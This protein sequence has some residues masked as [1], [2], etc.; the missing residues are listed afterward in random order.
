MN[1]AVSGWLGRMTAA[2]TSKPR[3]PEDVSTSIATLDSPV[4]QRFARLMLSGKARRG[5]YE[6]LSYP[7]KSGV[8]HEEAV[9]ALYKRIAFRQH[10]DHRAI[11]LRSVLFRLGNGGGVSDGFAPFAPLNELMLLRAGEDYGRIANGLEGAARSI[12]M[13]AEIL[14]VVIRALIVPV[15]V[16]LAMIGTLYVMGSW[17]VPDLEENMPA[18]QWQGL[19]ALL[20]YLGEFTANSGFLYV[21]IFLLAIGSVVVWSLPRWSGRGRVTA[22]RFFPYSL[23]RTFVG[24]AWLTVLSSMI[25]AG[26]P[27]SESLNAL[28]EIAFRQGNKYVS[29]RTAAIIKESEAGQKNISLSMERAGNNF[30]DEEL[31]SDLVMMASLPDFDKILGDKTKHWIEGRV[32]SIKATCMVTE[33]IMLLVSAILITVLMLSFY[34][35]TSQFQSSVGM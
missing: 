24:S 3:R 15:L 4:Q 8:A 30:P 22:D 34:S 10:K 6:K 1:E 5:L 31:I 29:S 19:G 16:L 14:G 18:D 12:E 20:R 11:V 7:I 9:A 17:M 21:L 28:H 33:I 2:R 26:R 27:V 13:G 23:Y 32:A 35:V 25:S